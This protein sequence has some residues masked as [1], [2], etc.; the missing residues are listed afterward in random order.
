MLWPMRKD[1]LLL[2]VQQF[3]KFGIV[4][5][6]N[7]AISLAVYYL[8]VHFN[9]ELYLAGNALGFLVSTLNAYLLNS[10][11]VFQDK[12][13][14]KDKGRN[15]DKK[16]FSIVQLWKTYAMYTF[17]LCISMALLYVL[18]Q[19]LSVSEKIAPIY[20]LMITV[21]LNFTLNRFWVYKKSDHSKKSNE[22]E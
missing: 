22:G 4:G 1:R 9:S 15:K 17:S 2:L 18:V 16:A 10:R 8:V 5:V 20:S 12:D 19:W 21:P 7:N 6:I 11:F 3:V 13:K 14:D